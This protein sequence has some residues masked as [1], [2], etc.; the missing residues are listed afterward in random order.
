MNNARVDYP[1]TE[2][3]RK[4]PLSFRIQF[5]FLHRFVLWLFADA[6]MHR[7]SKTIYFPKIVPFDFSAH[8]YWS[9]SNK[10]SQWITWLIAVRLLSASP[11]DC[12]GFT[13]FN[14]KLP[15][16]WNEPFRLKSVFYSPA[17]VIFFSMIKSRS[18]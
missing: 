16:N 10:S 1:E 8:Y 11:I 3:Q 12:I 2:M 14:W 13:R 18:A 5:H 15:H 17:N 6:R 7:H 9:K 4:T